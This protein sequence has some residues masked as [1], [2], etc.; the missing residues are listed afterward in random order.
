MRSDL[1]NT[2]VVMGSGLSGENM[3]YGSFEFEQY[4]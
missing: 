4:G 3:F 2:F 1:H